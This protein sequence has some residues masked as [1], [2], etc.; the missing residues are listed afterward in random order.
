MREQKTRLDW[1]TWMKKEA[2]IAVVRFDML[3]KVLNRP[4][5][6]HGG[7]CKQ[8]GSPGHVQVRCPTCR[9]YMNV[10][11]NGISYCA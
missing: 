9:D 1:S 4:I 10:P 8:K 7:H 2:P 6:I 11:N 5:E 3:R